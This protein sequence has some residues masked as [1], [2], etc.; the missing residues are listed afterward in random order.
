[1][2]DLQHVKNFCHQNHLYKLLQ[3]KWLPWQHSISLM[4]G[5]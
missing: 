5:C 2:M 1:M 3:T 4:A